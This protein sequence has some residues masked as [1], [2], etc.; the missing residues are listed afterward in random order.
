MS[1]DGGTGTLMVGAGNNAELHEKRNW[2]TVLK[3]SFI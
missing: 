1:R 3:S 2:K